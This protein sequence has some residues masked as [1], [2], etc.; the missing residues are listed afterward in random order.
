MFQPEYSYRGTETEEQILKRLRN[1]KA[2][3]EQGQSSGI[4]DHF[5]FNDNLEECYASLKV[6][7]PALHCITSFIFR[8]H[9]IVFLLKVKAD[10]FLSNN[11]HFMQK[12]L[13]LDETVNASP[14]SSKTLSIMCNLVFGLI[15]VMCN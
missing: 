5:L 2:E 15:V 7:F 6:T 12:L 9:I 14:E 4:F 11:F 1:A 8:Y 13:G 3:I 10:I